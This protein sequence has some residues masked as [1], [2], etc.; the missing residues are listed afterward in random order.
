MSSLW[1]NKPLSHLLSKSSKFLRLFDK[2]FSRV[3]CDTVGPNSSVVSPV[4]LAREKRHS[5][6]VIVISFTKIILQICPVVPRDFRLNFMPHVI[7]YLLF[8]NIFRKLINILGSEIT[9]SDRDCSW[10]LY[11]SVQCMK[12][13][14][15][16]VRTFLSLQLGYF[17]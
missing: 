7:E 4:P 11:E 10:C 6:S 13:W 3:V 2:I 16:P 17:I 15:E 8:L 12:F 9:Y 14:E 1:I 5:G